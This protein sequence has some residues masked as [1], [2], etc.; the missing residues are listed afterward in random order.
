LIFAFADDQERAGQA[1]RLQC[2]FRAALCA[3]FLQVHTSVPLS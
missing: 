1:P 3:A 2:F